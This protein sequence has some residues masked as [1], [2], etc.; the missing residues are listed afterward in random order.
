M[1][2]PQ[3]DRKGRRPPG[4]RSELARWGVRLLVILIVFGLGIAIGEALHDSPQSGET[5][6]FQ[7]TVPV[8][9]VPPGSTAVP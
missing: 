3:R 4:R 1:T 5:V 9:S 7:E 6:S 2:A 8:P